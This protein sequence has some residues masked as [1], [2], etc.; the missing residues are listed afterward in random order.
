MNQISVVFIIA[1]QGYQP[2]EYR[3]PK[4]I[5]E[6]AGIKVITASNALGTATAAD[7]STDQ[8]DIL[9]QDI[10]PA[11]H[12]GVF[13]V[14]GPGALENLDTTTVHHAL[15]KFMKASKPYGAICI[16][17]RILAR[18]GVLQH[19][20]ATGWDE[21][22]ELELI[23]KESGVT[24]IKQP[25]VTDGNVVTATDPRAAEEYGKALIKL[26]TN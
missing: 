18:A 5:L 13:I 2:V 9:V 25:V 8:V 11:Q 20:K 1:A 15:Q 26:F 17:P 24:Y 16:A 3:T 21:D 22:G 14:G 12:N 4:K 6:A 19:K 10:N 23:F 7:G